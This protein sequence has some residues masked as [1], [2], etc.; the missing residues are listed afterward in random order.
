MAQ[1]RGEGGKQSQEQLPAEILA[2]RGHGGLPETLRWARGKPCPSQKPRALVLSWVGF[3]GGG[4]GSGKL[5]PPGESCSLAAA[6][7]RTGQPFANCRLRWGFLESEPVFKQESLVSI[8][9]SVKRPRQVSLRGVLGGPGVA[10]GA[11]CLWI[12]PALGQGYRSP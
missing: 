10:L 3:R 7:D 11:S 2:P 9:A 5:T 12:R 6:G 4:L 1:G 8:G